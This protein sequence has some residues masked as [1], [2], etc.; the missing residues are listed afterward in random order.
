[1]DKQ[2]YS[3]VKVH[4]EL[5]KYIDC[6]W[7]GHN[8]E[9][10]NCHVI[11]DNTIELIFTINPI[12]RK[13]SGSAD[14]ETYASHLSGLKTKSQ[15]LQF[16]GGKI[17]GIRFKPE[18]IY[19][20][21][22]RDVSDLINAS[23]E[24]YLVFGDRIKT[25]EN[26]VLEALTYDRSDAFLVQ[27]IENH[28]LQDLRDLSRDQLVESIVSNIKRTNGAI[29]IAA[30]ADSAGC[31]IKTI[32]RRFK[33]KVGL[34]PKKYSGLYRLHQ[35]ILDIENP[36]DKLSDIAYD[37]GYYDQM[38]FIKEVKRYTGLTPK[39]IFAFKSGLQEPTL[40]RK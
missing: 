36:A 16:N 40:T 33:E 1:M 12:S 14:C 22:K 39:E 37:N 18:G 19:P 3:E 23:I 4:G 21:L 15:V 29:S 35:S 10:K 7:F 30:I 11:P 20:F 9:L 5:S 6:I 17:A 13:L 2:F 34:N 8:I 31:S 26:R 38:H 32:E 24:P 28:F 27:L 25:L